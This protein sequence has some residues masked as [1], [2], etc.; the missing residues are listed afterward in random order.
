MTDQDITPSEDTHLR[1]Y[2]L[3]MS[4]YYSTPHLLLLVGSN[5]NFEKSDYHYQQLQSLIDQFN[6][7]NP[8]IELGLSTLSFY[9]EMVGRHDAA[10][11]H[12]EYD[13]MPHT[14]NGQ[15]YFTGAFSSRP[16][17]K[18]A[19]REASQTLHAAQKLYLG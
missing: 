5:L 2:L 1:E 6:S 12:Y 9:D 10:M 16:N 17:L 3:E 19:I 13:F 4:Q 15:R 14:D 11:Y 7:V 18:Q 8:D